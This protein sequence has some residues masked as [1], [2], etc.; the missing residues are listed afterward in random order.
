M[1]NLTPVLLRIR[2]S[3]DCFAVALAIGASTKVRLVSEA[4]IIAASFGALHAGMTLIG[5]AAGLR[6]CVQHVV[7]S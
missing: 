7:L 5:R 3:M 2:L 6:D 4:I 1:D